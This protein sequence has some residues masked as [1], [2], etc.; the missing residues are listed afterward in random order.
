MKRRSGS[1][2]NNDRTG[3]IL[4][5][6]FQLVSLLG[7]G[8]QSAVYQ[9]RDLKDG[10]DVAIK[11]LV[12]SADQDSQERMFRE[13]FAMSQLLGTAAVRILAQSRTDDG[14]MALVMELLHGRDLGAELAQHKERGEVFPLQRIEETFAPIVSTLESAHAQGLVHRDLKPENIFLVAPEKGGGVRLLDFGFVKMTRSRAITGADNLAGSPSY[15]SPEAW[16]H[17]SSAVGPATDIYSLAVVLFQVLS[18]TV[19]FRGQTFEIMRD[20]T[21]APRPSLH[22]L[23]PDLP[24]DIDDWTQQALAISPA[25]RFTKITAMWRALLSSLSG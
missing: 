10:D 11:V 7:R 22:A 20:V 14:M 6:R 17:G 13:A 15:I 21:T 25:H 3:Q 24:S 18:G 19:P 1:S 4:G 23:R 9:A 5:E 2:R 8:G 12:Q 16:L